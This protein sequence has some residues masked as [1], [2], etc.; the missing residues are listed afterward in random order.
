M[1][2]TIKNP[3]VTV[4]PSVK[5]KFGTVSVSVYRDKKGNLYVREKGAKLTKA[6]KRKGLTPASSR[7][8]KSVKSFY[9]DP[10]NLGYKIRFSKPGAGIERTKHLRPATING[11]AGWFDM[12]NGKFLFK[13]Q[14][15]QTPNRWGENWKQYGTMQLNLRASDNTTYGLLQPGS[16]ED[17]YLTHLNAK[18]K[19]KLNEAL[20][21]LDWENEVYSHYESSDPD[22]ANPLG[23]PNVDEE[24]KGYDVVLNVIKRAVGAK[25][26]AYMESLGV[27][28]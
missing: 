16:L 28:A 20:N 14:R 26:R 11:R 6:E 19:A 10:E 9:S 8:A 13:E 3:V 18:E 27:S 21:A 23:R 1:A 15:G 2:S 25:W 22:E 24:K 7:L 12:R 17:F 4:S 5:V